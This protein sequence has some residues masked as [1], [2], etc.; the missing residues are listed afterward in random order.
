[1]LTQFPAGML[2]LLHSIYCTAPN[3][4]LLYAVGRRRIQA[5]CKGVFRSTKGVF[6]AA[7]GVFGPGKGVFERSK[8]VFENLKG[9]FTHPKGVFGFLKGVFMETR[10]I[11]LKWPKKLHSALKDIAKKQKT[12]LQTLITEALLDKYNVEHWRVGNKE[13]EV[14]E[15]LTRYNYVPR[16]IQ[17][18]VEEAKFNQQV[19]RVS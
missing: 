5:G 16:D 9:V 4:L 17:Q 15:I 11:K 2:A 18:A 14:E 13:K 8:G 7:K 1:M 19:R 10:D 3:W 12:S 6:N